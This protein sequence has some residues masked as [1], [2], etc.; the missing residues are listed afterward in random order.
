MARGQHNYRG[1]ILKGNVFFCQSMTKS[2]KNDSN[3][4]PYMLWKWFDYSENHNA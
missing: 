1:S 4:R 3:Y 2:M